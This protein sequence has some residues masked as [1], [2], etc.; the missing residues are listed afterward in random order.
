MSNWL[1]R[2]RC[3][4]HTRRAPGP[5]IGKNRV[6][7]IVA[8][9]VL[10]SSAAWG[11]TLTWTANSEPDLA[12]YRIYHCSQ[13][14]CAP[15]S[16]T[17]SLLTTLGTVTSFNIGT[18]SITQY[19]F[20]TAFD[21]ANNESSSSNLVTYVPASSQPPPPVTPPPVTLPPVIGASPESLSF[22]ATQGGV[23]P[24]SQT[25]IISNV[26]G[27][28]LSWTVNENASWLRLNRTSGTNNGTVTASVITGAVAAGVYN[29]MITVTATAASPV[30]VP[31]TFTVSPASMPPPAPTPPTQAPPPIPSG[32]RIS[33]MQ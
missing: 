14:P 12:G 22:A 16:G 8:V 29:T 32:L 7:V 33:A 26:G 13:Q 11:A 24:A 9:L 10:W 5:R 4:Y 30:T 28:T 19:Y 31:V 27:G 20:I 25:L 18:P 23:N 2:K 1:L 17:A 6:S 3:V 21:F 15:T